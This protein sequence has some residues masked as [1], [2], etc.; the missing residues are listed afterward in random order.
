MDQAIIF[1]AE[2]PT[3]TGPDGLP[4]SWRHFVHGMAGIDR[5]A[6]RHMLDSAASARAGG[7]TEE[8]YADW[9]REAS[10]RV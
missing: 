6:T 10:G 2:L 9:R 5:R 8:G 4:R 1:A 7:A 3:W